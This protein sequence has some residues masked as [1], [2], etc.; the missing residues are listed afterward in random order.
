MEGSY[1]PELE[2][3]NIKTPISVLKEQGENLKK[4]TKGVLTYSI[5]KKA[6]EGGKTA[7]TFDV[8]A[9][10]I[11]NLKYN[12]FRF[13]YPSIEVFP[14]LINYE[15]SEKG[16]RFLHSKPIKNWDEFDQTLQKILSSE[17][18]KNI[19]EKLLAHSKAAAEV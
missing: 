1:W 15:L 11:D 19:L 12:L 16:Q 17:K 18:T 3:K 4:I 9:P 13:S 8:V 7:I 5:N 6:L 14:M 2:T 10:L